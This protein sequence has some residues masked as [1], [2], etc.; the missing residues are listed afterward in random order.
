MNVVVRIPIKQLIHDPIGFA[1]D[2]ALAFV[3]T[4][5]IPIPFVGEVAVSFKKP[6][7]M[8]FCATI[9]SLTG[10]LLF[11][12]TILFSPSLL[13][14]NLGQTITS[15]LN[16]AQ[17]VP[18]DVLKDYVEAGFVDT[19]SPLKNPFSGQ[20][21]ANTT[22]TVTFHEF[23]SLEIN[24]AA[25]EG[26]EEGIDLVPNDLFFSTNQAAKLTTAPIIFNTLTGTVHTY[27]D[28]Y[29]AL[30]VEVTNVAQTV[31]TVYIHLQQI[32][33]TDNTIIHPG[34]PLGVMGSTG[35]STGPHLEYQVRLNQGGSWAAVNPT[36]YMH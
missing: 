21:M 34:Q 2:R 27:Q 13:L 31:K 4:L 16:P 20:G 24:G 17:S 5:F 29:G 6:L 3:V 23:E 11:I 9:I 15:L 19:D 7:L 14:Q 18:I 8:L 32:L 1:L 35:L 26:T 25:Y 30:I 33:V 12:T 28:S 36:A 10:L 22:A